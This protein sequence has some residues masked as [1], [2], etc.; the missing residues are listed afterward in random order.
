MLDD[1][2]EVFEVFPYESSNCGIFGYGFIHT[3]AKLIARFR[4]FDGG[5]IDVGDRDVRN[6]GLKDIGDVVVHDR[7]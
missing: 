4:T 5:V 1:S 2:I 6:F 3:I 7:N